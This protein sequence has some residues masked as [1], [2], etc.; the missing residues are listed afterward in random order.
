MAMGTE[1]N[2]QESGGGV[3]ENAR[4]LQQKVCFREQEERGVERELKIGT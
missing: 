2:G 4:W 3:D 1:G